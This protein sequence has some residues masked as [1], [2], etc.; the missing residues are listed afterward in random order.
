MSLARIEMAVQR[1]GID[2]VRIR[3]AETI[4]DA[5]DDLS[6]TDLWRGYGPTSPAIRV[7]LA[8]R[9]STDGWFEWDWA[10]Y[11]YTLLEGSS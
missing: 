8:D 9:L 7:L 2:E 4:D 3:I 11:T 6:A 10:T 1:R 5:L